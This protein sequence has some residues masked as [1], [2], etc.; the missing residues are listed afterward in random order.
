MLS[1]EKPTHLDHCRI[2]LVEALSSLVNMPSA[3]EILVVLHVCSIYI[4]AELKDVD[5]YRG[6]MCENGHG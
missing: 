5:G 4:F 3:V 6:S 2:C 1:T